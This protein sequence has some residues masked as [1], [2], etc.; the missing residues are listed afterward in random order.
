MTEK[1]FGQAIGFK[2]EIYDSMQNCVLLQF[3]K[4]SLANAKELEQNWKGQK[5]LRS[6]IAWVLAAISRDWRGLALV[7]VPPPPPPPLVKL[8]NWKL[9]QLSE[10]NKRNIYL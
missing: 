9:G 5:A 10:Y 2:W 6:V 1:V 7:C 4:K 8:V 3:W